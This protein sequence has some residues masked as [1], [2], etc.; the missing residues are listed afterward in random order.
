VSQN[1]EIEFK[2]MLTMEEYELLLNAFNINEK[3]IFSQENHY[4]DTA[5]FAL[6][7]N[8]AA[9]RI[10]QKEDHFEMT[11]KQTAKVGLLE[12][13]QQISKQEAYLAQ[14]TGKLPSGLIH[15]LLE[16]MEIPIFK[17]EYFGSLVTK[18]TEIEYKQGLLVLDHSYYLKKEDYEIE[19]EVE[20][21]LPGQEIFFQF[22]AQH[23]IP[24]RKTENKI[25]RFYHQKTIQ[26]NT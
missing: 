19:Y 18:R 16:E 8:G 26:E 4:F 13:N 1:I 12:S 22:L 23:G 15:G 17:M 9:L 20:N 25:R 11:L 6:K 10:R 5:D 2:N 24:N 3:Q 21:Y 7:E 14:Q